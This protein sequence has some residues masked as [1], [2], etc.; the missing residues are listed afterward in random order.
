MYRKAYVC[1]KLEVEEGADK[2]TVVIFFL[3]WNKVIVDLRYQ[4][5]ASVIA[6]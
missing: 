6:F 1:G 4:F 5:G 2:G 3:D